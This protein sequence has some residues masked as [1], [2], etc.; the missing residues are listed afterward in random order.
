MIDD[1]I[2]RVLLHCIRYYNSELNCMRRGEI[3]FV[4]DLDTEDMGGSSF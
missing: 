1:I 3:L 4:L 2:V